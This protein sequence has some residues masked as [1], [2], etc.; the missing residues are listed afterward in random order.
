METMTGSIGQYCEPILAVHST[1][2]STHGPDWLSGWIAQL[3]ARLY[4]GPDGW[5]VVLHNAQL[6]WR[7]TVRVLRRVARLAKQERIVLSWHASRDDCATCASHKHSSR[8]RH[9]R[10]ALA[11]ATF[12]HLGVGMEPWRRSEEHRDA[13]SVLVRGRATE[14]TASIF[15]DTV[16]VVQWKY[17][18]L[19]CM[20]RVH[21]CRLE[22]LR[23]CD[24]AAR[25]QICA[26]RSLVQPIAQAPPYGCCNSCICTVSEQE[27][28]HVPPLLPRLA[29]HQQGSLPELRWRKWRC[30]QYSADSTRVTTASSTSVS[31]E[32]ASYCIGAH[33][34][35][36]HHR[37]RVDVASSRQELLGFLTMPGPSREMQECP[38]VLRD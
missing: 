3:R 32:N 8:C 10:G 6:K 21:G 20:A 37:L 27:I 16:G 23:C 29:C 12:S 15:Y 35:V 7:E 18:C 11:V 22:R 19:R 34:H 5:H 13:C 33:S 38:V 36:A 28:D 2:D 9:R 31:E 25:G 30:G 1:Q 4:Q 14:P 26:V 24:V 17:A